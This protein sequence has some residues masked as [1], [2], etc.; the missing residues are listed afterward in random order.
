MNATMMALSRLAVCALV[1]ILTSPGAHPGATVRAAHLIL[2]A[3][4]IVDDSAEEIEKPKPSIIVIK[5]Q[6][7]GLD[8]IGATAD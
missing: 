4:R 7:K 1:S 8:G 5:R 2:K 3:A 6:S